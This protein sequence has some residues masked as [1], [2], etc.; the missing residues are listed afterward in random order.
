[1]RV[2][3]TDEALSDLN[4]IL[5]FLADNYPTVCG[6]FQKRLRAIERRI[7]QWPKSAQ[8]IEQRPGVRRRTVHSISL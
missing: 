3:F 6:P 8:M 2:I 4:E 1:M 5:E 7:G